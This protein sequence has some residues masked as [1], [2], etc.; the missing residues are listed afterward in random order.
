M[1]VF[2][3]LGGCQ[4]EDSQQF[5]HDTSKLIIGSWDI[6]SNN[7]EATEDEADID[8]TNE[9]TTYFAD[10]TSR[11]YVDVRVDLRI[12]GIDI[13]DLKASASGQWKIED[14]L[15]H[16]I[17]TAIEI[18]SSSSDPFISEFVSMLEEDQKSEPL[19]TYAIIRHDQS[20]FVLKH[21]ETK[22]TIEMRRR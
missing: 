9:T 6:I 10:G 3:S 16:D 12:D 7:F 22:E 13:F 21:I 8:F 18:T 17:L 20:T 5:S 11:S 14:D 2:V 1:L 4:N 15:L 19:S